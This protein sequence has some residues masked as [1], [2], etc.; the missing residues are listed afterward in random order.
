MVF[1]K[2][3]QEIYDLTL[4]LLHAI[5]HGDVEKYKKYSSKTLTAIEP[6]TSGLV[7]KGLEFHLFFLQ[8]TQRK[9]FHIE[10]VNP[11]IKVY[12]DTAYIA[13]TLIENR[14]FDGK[15]NLKSVFETRIYHKEE[16]QWKMVH[17]HR[18]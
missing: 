7:V 14:L 11:I 6:E 16:G 8:N 9:E 15:F 4:D 17:F 10:L 13:Y 2:E 12:N 3:E 1:S 18:N 5:R